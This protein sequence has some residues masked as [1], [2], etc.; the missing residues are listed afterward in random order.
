MEEEKSNVIK[1]D[2]VDTG[3]LC[4]FPNAPMPKDNT[5][6]IEKN[7]YKIDR[8]EETEDKIIIHLIQS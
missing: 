4:M 5:I 8:I 3:K 7:V 2:A 6:T 1:I